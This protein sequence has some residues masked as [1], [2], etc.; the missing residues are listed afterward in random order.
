MSKIR[1]TQKP[2][3]ISNA[4]WKKTKQI[5]KQQGLDQ[6]QTLQVA[7]SIQAQKQQKGNGQKTLGTQF[8]V[9]MHGGIPQD[10][11]YRIAEAATGTP[12]L[13]G[14]KDGCIVAF[15]DKTTAAVKQALAETYGGRVSIQQVNVKTEDKEATF[16]SATKDL[17]NLALKTGD[18][19]DEQMKVH[20]MEIASTP[21]GT[22]LLGFLANLIGD[23]YYAAQIGE[24]TGIRGPAFGNMIDGTPRSVE[25]LI[26]CNPLAWMEHQV[27]L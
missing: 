12:S 10:V 3:G 16:V 26:N 13:I 27:G 7:A 19:Q 23:G 5:A 24:V 18:V 11:Q 4:T 6:Q 8:V 17:P 14:S 20:G 25:V 21:Q 1:K 9:T 22:E 15:N 2:N